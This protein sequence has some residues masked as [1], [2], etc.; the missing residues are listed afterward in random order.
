MKEGNHRVLAGG[1]RKL[2]RSLGKIQT[3][4]EK[5]SNAWDRSEDSDGNCIP[6]LE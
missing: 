6:C 3:V 1:R 5:M 4:V 2:V